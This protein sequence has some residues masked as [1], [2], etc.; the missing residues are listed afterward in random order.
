MR[1]GNSFWAQA[2]V[3]AITHV[4]NSA[5]LQTV[6]RAESP[7]YYDLIAEFEKITGVPIVIN[8][9]FN[10]RG[11]PIVWTPGDAYLC[12]MRTNMDQL[13]LGP[14]L[15]EKKDQSAL[16]EGLGVRMDRVLAQN[17]RMRMLDR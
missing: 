11:E 13:V 10:V 3:P 5:R 2:Q 16:R 8:T 9:S 7:L 4:D 12:F 6:T 1:D 14:Y 17:Q 15:L